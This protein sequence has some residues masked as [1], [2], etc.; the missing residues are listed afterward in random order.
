MLTASDSLNSCGKPNFFRLQGLRVCLRTEQ[1]RP[2]RLKP[3][4]C[5]AFTAWLKPCPDEKRMFKH[6]S[7]AHTIQQTCG[8][9]N[10]AH[11]LKNGLFCKLLRIVRKL[12]CGN[13]PSPKN[14]C[15]RY[16][17]VILYPC[18]DWM[19]ATYGAQNLFPLL[20]P[21]ALG[22]A[23]SICEEETAPASRQREHSFSH[24]TAAGFGYRARHSG[25]DPAS[26]EVL[27]AIQECE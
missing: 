14:H 27:R 7:K 26:E 5:M 17:K 1:S 2:Q 20:D 9:L 3:G 6:N 11:L 24:G 18:E 16:C 25:K 19:Q 21:C 15:L 10:S 12:S 8:G 22:D 4:W 13:N 23:G